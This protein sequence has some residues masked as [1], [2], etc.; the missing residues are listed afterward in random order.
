MT[1]QNSQG[2]RDSGTG[3]GRSSGVFTE[4]AKE[5]KRKKGRRAS[6]KELKLYEWATE[7]GG[8]EREKDGEKK[9]WG[10]QCMQSKRSKK[11]E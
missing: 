5:R 2:K 3:R 11:R 10:D 7:Y 4:R 9:T 1:K 8:G 6:V